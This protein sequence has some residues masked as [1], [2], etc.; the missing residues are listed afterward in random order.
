MK[1]IINDTLRRLADR[2]MGAISAE[3][4]KLLD[5]QGAVEEDVNISH[6]PIRPEEI[7]LRNRAASRLTHQEIQNQINLEDIINL[8]DQNLACEQENIGNGGEMDIDWF[9]QF[10]KY[11]MG[12]S[13]DVMKKGW[14]KV[15]A[16][17]IRKPNSFSF[18]TLNLM[19]MLTKQ[20]A[21][22]VRKLAQYVI[23][24]SNGKAGY[25]LSS[26]RIEEIEF[27]DILL[28]A[29]LRLIDSSSELGLT[30][31]KGDEEDFNC[32]MRNKDIG[33]FFNSE[34]DQMFFR[35]YKLTSTGLELM[36]LNDDVEL[37]I[38]YLKEYAESLT[39]IDTTM[40]I[41]CSK[42]IN[43]TSDNV[44]LDEEHPYFRIGPK[45][46]EKQ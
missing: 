37:N 42:I 39:K 33:L 12:V 11:A 22:T 13:S 16:N 21:E 40:N 23:Y 32:L 29:E 1:K 26:K 4:Q 34:R 19:S 30:I 18:R 6:Q 45:F 44:D 20:E 8:A 28:L 5:C 24:S 38:D 41:T 3:K 31:E 17:E 35:I 2:Y 7:A 15:L 43:L 36:K 25:I 9:N 10:S 46:A 14:A 27:D